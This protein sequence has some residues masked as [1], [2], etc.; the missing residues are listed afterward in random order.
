MHPLASVRSPWLT[1]MTGIAW[2]ATVELLVVGKD[3]WLPIATSSWLVGTVRCPVATI[4]RL[5]LGT[6]GWLVGKGARCP[7]SMIP[8]L[9]LGTSG[10]VG[11]DP[12]SLT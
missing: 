6:S 2:F 3:C 5:P 1:W 7:V 8:R 12:V 4:P 11:T 10:S 9:P